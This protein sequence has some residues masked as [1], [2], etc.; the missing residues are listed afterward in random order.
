MDNMFEEKLFL[1]YRFFPS[2]LHDN[3]F[4]FLFKIFGGI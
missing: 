1:I 3:L 2:L 4:Q